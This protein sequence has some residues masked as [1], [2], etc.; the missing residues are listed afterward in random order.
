[1]GVSLSV[2]PGVKVFWKLRMGL[3]LQVR[4]PPQEDPVDVVPRLHH[5]QEKRSVL[6]ASCSTPAGQI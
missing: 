3:P 4:P 5:P 2:T 6:V 1:M